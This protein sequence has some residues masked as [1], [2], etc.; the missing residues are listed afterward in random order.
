M[1]ACLLDGDVVADGRI[2]L[3]AGGALVAHGEGLFET[4]PVLGGRARF[5]AAH[6]RRLDGGCRAL[7][8]GPGPEEAVVGADVAKLAAALRASE[9]SLR[10]SVFKDGGR[11]HRLLVPSPLPDDVGSAVRLGIVA[12]GLNGPRSLATLKT[13]NYLVPRLAHADGVW[14]GFDEVLFTLPDGT[15]LEGTRSSAFLV[16]GGGVVTAPLWMPILAG[17]TREVILGCARRD[18]IP[19]A[20]RPFTVAEML[21]A[22]E[23][24]VSASVRGVRPV[25]SLEGNPLRVVEGPVTSRIAAAYR[26]ALAA[27]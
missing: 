22:G 8:F 10:I 24:F 21:A 5:L 1:K 18:G 6:L 4:L 25:K 11:V 14:R 27:G 16:A 7:G 15:V 17:V 23:A 20:E 26:A 12:E 13:L 19:V 9:F 2:A 3:D